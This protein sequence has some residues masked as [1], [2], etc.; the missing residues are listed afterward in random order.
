MTDSGQEAFVRRS[1]LLRCVGDFV[2]LLVDGSWHVIA[3]Y[4]VWSRFEYMCEL[5]C[6]DHT[7][8]VKAQCFRNDVKGRQQLKPLSL[9]LCIY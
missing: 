6:V 5:D 3:T 8:Q 2:L 9:Q 7:A 1:S 4:H